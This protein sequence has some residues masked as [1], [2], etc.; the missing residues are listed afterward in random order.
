MAKGVRKGKGKGK[1]K[2]AKNPLAKIWSNRGQVVTHRTLD[3]PT[4]LDI[5]YWEEKL[6]KMDPP[7]EED[8]YA[9]DSNRIRGENKD[10]PN[11]PRTAAAEKLLLG[12]ENNSLADAIENDIRVKIKGIV[13][14]SC[15]EYSP[16]LSL[17]SVLYAMDNVPDDFT[18]ESLAKCLFKYLVGNAPD[19]V[20]KLSH[21]LRKT[22]R[23]YKSLCYGLLK[24]KDMNSAADFYVAAA[25]MYLGI[26]ILLVRPKQ[27]KSGRTGQ[28]YYEYISEFCLKE[29]KHM[30]TSDCQITLVFNGVNHYTCF[31]CPSLGKL[32]ND[33]VTLLENIESCYSELD[34]FRFMQHCPKC[35]C[36]FGPQIKLAKVLISSMVLGKQY[37]SLTCQFLCRHQGRH[38][39]KD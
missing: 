30:K 15:K 26:P 24:G 23:S 8:A 14:Q 19:I 1:G 2:A 33:G 7:E 12:S 9:A 31:F 10:I 16:V 13:V 5:K 22:T 39:E 21:H 32:L 27:L 3:E 36:T 28:V 6:D 35:S 11:I 25:S 34:K 38:I 18:G 20:E 37:L 4:D 29:H 17:T